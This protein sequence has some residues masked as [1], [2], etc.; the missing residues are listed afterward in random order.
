MCA[1]HPAT[2]GKVGKRRSHRITGASGG[3]GGVEK[4]ERAITGA[5]GRKV[6]EVGR[7]RL[8]GPAR[9]TVGEVGIGGRYECGEPIH[10]LGQDD[11]RS[12]ARPAARCARGL[13][14]SAGG[15]LCAPDDGYA[16]AKR[17]TSVAALGEGQGARTWAAYA[18]RWP[19]RA[20]PPAMCTARRARNPPGAG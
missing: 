8:R 6:G 12:E 11:A 4:A 16:R 2:G 17:R 20:P 3:V 5:A 7:G 18:A 1:A 13:Q 19:S 10:V 14:A 15:Q 9:R